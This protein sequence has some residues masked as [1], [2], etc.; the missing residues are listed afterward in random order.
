MGVVG[1]VFRGDADYNCFRFNKAGA[2]PV[3]NKPNQ[4]SIKRYEETSSSLCV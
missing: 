4:P 1:A 2:D 3:Q